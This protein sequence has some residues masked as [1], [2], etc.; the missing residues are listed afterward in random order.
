MA[1]PNKI[2]LD[3]FP[4][5]T[6]F[7]P[8]INSICAIIES[9]NRELHRA[10][11][12]GTLLLLWQAVYKNGYYLEFDEDI[13]I[14]FAVREC[15]LGFDDFTLI[16]ETFISKGIFDKTL[17]EKHKILTSKGLQ[18]QYLN[19]AKRRSV[20]IE[21]RYSLLND[22]K[23]S[24]NVNDNSVNV[25]N[26][27]INVCNNATN[28]RK[29]NKRKENETKLNNTLINNF[30]LVKEK[31]FE[32]YSSVTYNSW[33][34]ELEVIDC[35]DTTLTLA[36]RYKFTADTI[37][38]NYLDKITEFIEEVYGKKYEVKIDWK[39]GV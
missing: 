7:E 36:V 25:C 22:V 38:D 28:K 27:S 32:C 9:K 13:L 11:V 33:L 4:V 34:A 18:K 1:R 39:L 20:E 31:L 2:G 24:I 12:I 35:D 6:E 10:T 37:T 8:K 26:N 21:K 3:Y 23:K 30:E 15:G 16:L 5:D 29:E 17:Y 14:T 19:I